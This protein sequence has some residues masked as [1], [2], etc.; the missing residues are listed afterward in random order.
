MRRTQCRS[1]LGGASP[2]GCD[3]ARREGAG[4]TPAQYRLHR[5]ATM[6]AAMRASAMFCRLAEP[7]P[8]VDAAMEQ[9]LTGI[10]GP[11]L[12]D[13]A[14]FVPAGPE[15]IVPPGS[16]DVAGEGAVW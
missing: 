13:N 5:L 11:A 9:M 1:R 15:L 3:Q 7:A 16:L 4:V 10:F 14:P 6:R 12:R 2:I 8:L